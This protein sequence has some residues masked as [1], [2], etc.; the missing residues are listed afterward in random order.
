ME[1]TPT[2]TSV[3]RGNEAVPDARYC[4]DANDAQQPKL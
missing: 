1:K 3:M 2:T 4:I